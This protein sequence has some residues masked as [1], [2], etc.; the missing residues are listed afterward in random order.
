MKA[1]INRGRAVV[2]A[3]LGI[4][5]L[6]VSAAPA[7]ASALPLLGGR[8]CTTSNTSQPFAGWSDTNQYTLVAG[9]S[10]GSSTSGWTL[11]G[12]AHLVSGGEPWGAAGSVSPS[13][14]SLPQGSWAQSPFSCV[15][16]SDPTWRFFVAN[17]A[18][19]S[20]LTVSVVYTAP[21]LGQV[22]TPVGTQTVSSGWQPSQTMMTADQL[23]S[24]LKGGA[25][26]VA[27]RFTATSGTSNVDDVFIDPRMGWR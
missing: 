18:G 5:V 9:S 15:D 26:D 25:T 23:E 2:V 12:G 27:L 24:L 17:A 4:G 13:S 7:S 20:R 11:S 10:F 6:A 8:S 1:Y 14:L 16:M 3:L 21:L 22:V 19:S